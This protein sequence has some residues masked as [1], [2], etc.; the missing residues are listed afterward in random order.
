MRRNIGTIVIEGA[1][2]GST[3]SVNGLPVGTAPLA[4]PVRVAKGKV[5]VEVHAAGFLAGTS[6]LEVRGGDEQR[7][8]MA[9]EREKAAVNPPAQPQPMA[10]TKGARAA[11]D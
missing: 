4:S 2:A 6:R 11:R 1:P 10:E 3:I 9:L 5:D 8:V 7:V